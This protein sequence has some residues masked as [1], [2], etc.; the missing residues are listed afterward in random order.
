MTYNEIE[1]VIDR[2]NSRKMKADHFIWQL[3]DQ[4]DIALVW[5]GPNAG[6]SLVTRFQY[7]PDKFYLIKEAGEY[8]S[9]VLDAYS[10]LQV[11][12]KTS[13]RRKGLLF[14]AFNEVIF[15]HL[16]ISRLSQRVTTTLDNTS[17]QSLIEKLGF[18]KTSTLDNKIAYTK[19]LNEF[20]KFPQEN[21]T[22]SKSELEQIE[23]KIYDAIEPIELISHQLKLIGSISDVNNELKNILKIRNRL[24]SIFYDEKNK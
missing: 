23:K 3:T 5:T 13:H 10:D 1:S 15:R 22:P 2:L 21:Y 24:T 18:M 4:V 6:D 7:R 16:K 17:A 19:S 14:N 12:S 11:Y 9:I 8:C 20:Q